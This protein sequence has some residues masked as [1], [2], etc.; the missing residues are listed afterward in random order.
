MD[1]GIDL[2]T[3]WTKD[4]EDPSI[5][6]AFAFDRRSKEGR[7]TCDQ[8]RAIAEENGFDV[9]RVEIGCVFPRIR[10]LPIASFERRAWE[11]PDLE[12]IAAEAENM[13]S[14]QDEFAA[15]FVHTADDPSALD[16]HNDAIAF[17]RL[18]EAA[19]VVLERLEMDR[20]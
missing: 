9:T 19:R 14:F 5:H 16:A 6:R 7:R 17:R 4:R 12:A 11:G 2:A 1:R 8:V 15:A 18:A 3:V 20:L 13:A 10:F